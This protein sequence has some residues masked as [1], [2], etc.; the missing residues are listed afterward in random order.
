MS[1]KMVT[2][3]DKIQHFILCF[4]VT[5]ALGWQIGT[6]MALTIEGTQA[7]AF[8]RHY[9]SLKYYWWKDTVADLIADG[10]GILTGVIIKG[11]L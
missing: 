2:V 4:L 7:E 6:T 10:L 3:K 9:G 8:Y 11:I 1:S 5:L